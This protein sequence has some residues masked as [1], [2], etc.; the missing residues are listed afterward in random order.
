MNGLNLY[1]ISQMIN[2]AVAYVKIAYEWNERDRKYRKKNRIAMRF[3]V[4][5][6][7]VE[8]N[9]PFSLDLSL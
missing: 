8:I 1:K 6:S 4:L 5:L 7:I 3:N 2:N 9:A